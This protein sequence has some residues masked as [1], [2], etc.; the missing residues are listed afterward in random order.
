MKKI[1]ILISALL[2]TGCGQNDPGLAKNTGI[3]DKQRTE[4]AERLAPFG[5]V[6]L[7]AE[8]K[9]F[10]GPKSAY[11]V[12]GE[13]VQV[14][15]VADLPGK[16]KYAGCA[17]CH[18]ANGGGGIGPMLAGQSADYIV[19]RLTAYRAGETVGTQSALMWGQAAG[20]SN[21]DITDL[22]EY[23]ASF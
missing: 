5:V 6:N 3:T 12:N 8:P 2:I 19:D 21:T 15:A 16:A 11:V 1:A 18:G 14:A 22:A 23:I 7:S 17:A 20:L 4:I 10:N 9:N 13:A